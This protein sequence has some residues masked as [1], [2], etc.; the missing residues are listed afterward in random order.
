MPVMS[1]TLAETLKSIV[2]GS[3]SAERKVIGGI[4]F[5]VIVVVRFE[6]GIVAFTDTP[7]GPVTTFVVTVK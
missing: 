7:F 1:F 4:G 5:T 2:S 6:F 3:Q